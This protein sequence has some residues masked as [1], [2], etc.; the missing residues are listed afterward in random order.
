MI[1]K[2]CS[3]IYGE[4]LLKSL[5]DPMI[6]I[7]HKAPLKCR[8]KFLFKDTDLYSVCFNLPYCNLLRI[9]C[10]DKKCRHCITEFSVKGGKVEFIGR[11][12]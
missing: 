6:N 4:K 10:N 3:D 9:P 11:C 5:N 12:K 1:N 8:A 2:F 7:K